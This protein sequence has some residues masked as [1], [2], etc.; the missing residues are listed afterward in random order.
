[1]IQRSDERQ[2]FREKLQVERRNVKRREGYRCCRQGGRFSSKP[3]WLRQSI[4]GVA[5][6][7]CAALTRTCFSRSSQHA[8]WSKGARRSMSSGFRESPS[9]SASRYRK[10]EQLENVDPRWGERRRDIDRDR[11]AARCNFYSW[12]YY[13]NKKRAL[14][15]YTEIRFD[16]TAAKRETIKYQQFS[17]AFRAKTNQEWNLNIDVSR[18]WNF[19]SRKF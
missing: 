19:P 18:T 10:G 3:G 6:T 1:M 7:N 16:V 2:D 11:Y 14:M 13:R 8:D 17:T 4:S 12:K 15:C 5:P 9:A